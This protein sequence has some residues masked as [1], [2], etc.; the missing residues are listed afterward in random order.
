MRP[1]ASAN[2]RAQTRERKRAQTLARISTRTPTRTQPPTS[3]Q[4]TRAEGSKK[5]A[6]LIG[7]SDVAVSLAKID[8]SAAALSKGD[9]MYFG[10]EPAYMQHVLGRQDA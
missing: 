1:S 6:D 5:A 10:Q 8:R 2:A 4:V 7:E 3:S 9:K